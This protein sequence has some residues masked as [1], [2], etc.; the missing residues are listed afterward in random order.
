VS[1]LQAQLAVTY[2]LSGALEAPGLIEPLNR[3]GY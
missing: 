3:V 2:R 1:L